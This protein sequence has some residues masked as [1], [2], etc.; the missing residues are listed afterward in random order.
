MVKYIQITTA[1]IALLLTSCASNGRAPAGYSEAQSY[2]LSEVSRSQ[3][4]QSD[5][6]MIAYSA[7]LDLFVKKPEETRKLLNEQIKVNNGYITKE[8]DNYITARIPAENMDNF[9]TFAK[10]LGKVNNESKTG[11]DITDQYRDNVL[12]LESLRSVQ[13]RYITLLDRANSVSDI[14]IVEKEL[15]RINLEIERLEGRI[16]HAEQS[17][18]Y[19]IVTV[20]FREK[21]KPGPVGWVFYGLFQGIKWLFVW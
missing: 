7:S 14:L 12:R 2:E 4:T 19:S 9:L 16:K 21:T 6:R 1:I 13:K 3:E 11:T 8:A 5:N 15:E 18:A 20:R 17:A 10:T